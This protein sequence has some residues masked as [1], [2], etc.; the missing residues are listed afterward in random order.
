VLSA[1]EAGA[2]VVDA[3]SLEPQAARLAVI[4]THKDSAKILFLIVFLPLKKL[5]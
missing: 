4:A 2:V 5:D 1:S 3:D